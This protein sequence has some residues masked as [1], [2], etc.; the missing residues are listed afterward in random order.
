MTLNSQE[1]VNACF[2]G[3][4]IFHVCAGERRDSLRKREALT[5]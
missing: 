2:T 4:L 3:A 5:S 1:F